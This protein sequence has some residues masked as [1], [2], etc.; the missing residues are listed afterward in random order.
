MRESDN[1]M[2]VK[3][4][5][6]WKKELEDSVASRKIIKTLRPLVPFDYFKVAPSSYNQSIQH[7]DKN[8]QGSA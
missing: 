2:L 7:E 1:S 3:N 5:E 4:K 6:F 8:K